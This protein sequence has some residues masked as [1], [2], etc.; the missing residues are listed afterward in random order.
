V[1]GA[2]IDAEEKIRLRAGSE[3]G[4]LDGAF[5]GRSSSWRVR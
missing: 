4:D 2:R 1:V 5:G 3:T